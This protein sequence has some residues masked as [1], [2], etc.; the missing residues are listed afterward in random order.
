MST[1]ARIGIMNE[2]GSVDNVYLHS[3]GY[4]E[5]A[6]KMLNT[7]YN[8]EAKM[9]ALLAE[10]DMSTIN[11]VIGGKIDFDDYKLRYG[12]KQCVFYSR[13]RGEAEGGLINENVTEFRGNLEDVDYLY[14]FDPIANVFRCT[15]GT[16]TY[17]IPTNQKTI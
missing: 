14:L 13:D 2:D 5:H 6:G 16:R 9:R 17:R 8:T 10:G 12:L 7:H 11:E 3:D 15:D 1:T 4:P